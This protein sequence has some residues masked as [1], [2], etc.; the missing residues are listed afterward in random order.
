MT[1]TDFWI[2]KLLKVFNKKAYL[3]RIKIEHLLKSPDVEM[4]KLGQRLCHNYRYSYYVITIGMVVFVG[5]GWTTHER[6]WFYS[7]YDYSTGIYNSKTYRIKL[8][9]Y[10]RKKRNKKKN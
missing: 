1:I 2:M 3:T 8:K 7:L 4:R 10:G 6:P 5:G 9:K